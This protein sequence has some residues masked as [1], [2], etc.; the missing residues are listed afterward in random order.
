MK[1][2]QPQRLDEDEDDQIPIIDEQPGP[3]GAAPARAT[4]AGQN[5]EDR[6]KKQSKRASAD[7][8]VGQDSCAD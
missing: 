3:T 7:I 8:K 5:A 2:L 6:A 4:S 1:G